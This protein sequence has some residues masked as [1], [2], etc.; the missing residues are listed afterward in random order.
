VST[1]ILF[2]GSGNDVGKKK[3]RGEN[4]VDECPSEI[5]CQWMSLRYLV[6]EHDDWYTSKNVFGFPLIQGT[7]YCTVC[8]RIGTQEQGFAE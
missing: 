7:T 1:Y 2:G 6:R 3:K 8:S 5:K 4:D